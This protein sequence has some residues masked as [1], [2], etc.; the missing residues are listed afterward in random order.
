MS[1]AR[2][3]LDRV[4]TENA[5]GWRVVATNIGRITTDDDWRAWVD[6]GCP[7]DDA[8]A[9]NANARVAVDGGRKVRPPY[10]AIAN[11]GADCCKACGRE[12]VTSASTKSGWKHRDGWKGTGQ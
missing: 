11:D 10:H 3:A 6:A 1:G 7:R 8:P 2:D 9:V 5:E 4:G 12:I